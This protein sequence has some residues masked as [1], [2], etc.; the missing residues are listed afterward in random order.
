MSS[1]EHPQLQTS[2]TDG[3]LLT[4]LRARRWSQPPAS[5][6]ALWSFY[7]FVRRSTG[8]KIRTVRPADIG[9]SRKKVALKLFDMET[10]LVKQPTSCDTFV[11]LPPATRNDCVVFGK[12]SDRPAGEVQEV[13]YVP[14][15]HHGA[16][17]K[18]QVRALLWL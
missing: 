10:G 5:G 14:K 6:K 17:T 12:N 16:S 1:R 18:L 15:T 2:V 3:F 8:A 4:H 11:A 9:K 7:E 13:V